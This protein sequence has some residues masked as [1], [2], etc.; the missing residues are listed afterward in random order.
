MVL[1]HNKINKTI[2]EVV[3]TKILRVKEYK[4]KL[5]LITLLIVVDKQR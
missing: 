5:L 3:I 4:I 2:Q 1:L